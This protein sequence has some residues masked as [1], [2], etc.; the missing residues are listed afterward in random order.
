MMDT[1]AAVSPDAQPSRMA[2]VAP[3]IALAVACVFLIGAVT[4]PQAESPS[5]IQIDV[6][7]AD[8]ADLQMLP[9]I[10]PALADRIITDRD[11]RGPFDDA[12]DLARVR[13]V[14]DRTVL[15]LE[16]YL[17]FNATPANGRLD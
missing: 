6:N 9:G 5:S 2:I 8:L 7:A 3:A 11:T 12:A 17:A 15:N 14:G 16:P 4:R 10:G 13:G 1:H